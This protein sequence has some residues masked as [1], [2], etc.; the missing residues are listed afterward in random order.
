M[1]ERPGML[2]EDIRVT[3]DIAI[4]TI[5]EGHLKVLLIRRRDT[6]FRNKLALPGGHVRR[7]EDVKSAADRELGE[8]TNIPGKTLIL[9]QLAVKSEP[10]RDPRTRVITVPFVAIAPDVSTP[11]AGS[12]AL[13]VTWVDADGVVDGSVK[14]AFDHREIVRDAREHVRAKLESTT[15]ATGFCADEF[16]IGDLRTVYETV[17]G[18]Q[19][20]PRNFNR[21]VLH[22]IG[23]VKP[24][25]K[26]RSTGLGR[27]AMLY[28]A[29]GEK[30]LRPPML[31][32]EESRG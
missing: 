18:I 10:K 19:L 6:P 24:T 23:F 26:Q 28:R 8:E 17:W 29:G 12:D 31:R 15:I 30:I 11:K 1:A 4:F 14:V 3:T 5:L 27:P 16:T 9:D 2:D 21:K 7:N 22:T 32:T 25:G 13:E 20:D